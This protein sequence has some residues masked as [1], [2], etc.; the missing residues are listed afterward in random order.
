MQIVTFEKS[1]K[2]NNL[3]LERLKWKALPLNLLEFSVEYNF[4]AL[5]TSDF[6]V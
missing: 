1:L 4:S 3:S 6:R 2:Y 5:Y